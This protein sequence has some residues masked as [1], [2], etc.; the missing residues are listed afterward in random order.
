MASRWIYKCK[1][2]APWAF[3]SAKSDALRRWGL[4]LETYAVSFTHPRLLGYVGAEL[5]KRAI[6]PCLSVAKRQPVIL[7]EEAT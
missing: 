6:L 2:L 7:I 5:T 4:N 1:N 3:Y